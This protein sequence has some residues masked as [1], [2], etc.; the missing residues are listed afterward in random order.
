MMCLARVVIYELTTFLFYPTLHIPAALAQVVS[1][2]SLWASLA[3]VSDAFYS[4]CKCICVFESDAAT[5]SIS[6]AY[7]TYVRIHFEQEELLDTEK[8]D[9]LDACIV[10]K[11]QKSQFIFDILSFSRTFWIRFMLPWALQSRQSSAT[12]LFFFKKDPWHNT[13]TLRCELFLVT[14][15]IMR[16]CCRISYSS[17]FL[18]NLSS[19]P[20]AV[21]INVNVWGQVF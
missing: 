11:S 13:I 1:S 19:K 8:Q 18:L 12:F 2:T 16:S 17:P 6:Y 21:G 10:R 20:C 9:V 3:R 4:V 7:L 5:I 14:R 15:H